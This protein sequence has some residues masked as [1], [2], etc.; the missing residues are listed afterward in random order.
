MSKNSL[1]TKRASLHL[2]IALASILIATPTTMRAQADTTDE[3]ETSWTASAHS[4]Y[5]NKDISRG[6]DLSND[7]AL[8][9][10]GVRLEHSIGF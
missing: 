9:L 3:K 5:Q 8:L 2:W 10:Y 1:K 6:V 7:L 4:Q